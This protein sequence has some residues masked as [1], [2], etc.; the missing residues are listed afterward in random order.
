MVTSLLI[1]VET[2]TQR[3]EITPHWLSEI[4]ML[5]PGFEALHLSDFKAR[6]WY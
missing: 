4:K 5:E 3:L 2:E 1:A 6:T